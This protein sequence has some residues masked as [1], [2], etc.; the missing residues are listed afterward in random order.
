MQET[1]TGKFT[2]EE[3]FELDGAAPKG[4][5]LEYLGGTIYLNG[6]VFEPSMGW[7]A[8]LDL[9]GASREHGQIKNNVEVAISNQLRDRDCDIFSSD[10][11]SEVALKSGYVYPDLVVSCEP[12]YKG[13]T[14]KNPQFLL[15]ILSPSTAKYDLTR[16]KDAYAS[17]ASALEFWFID[18]KQVR[19][20][21]HVRSQ[22]GWTAVHYTDLDVVVRSDHFNLD[23]PMREVYR[24]VF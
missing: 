17:R 13:A 23:I 10:M 22:D 18:Q 12:E 21:Q 15:E 19:V 24:K 2:E 7:D 3:Y 14:L 8:A 9:A 11:R 5:R 20:I 4:V 16:K 6:Y 1:K